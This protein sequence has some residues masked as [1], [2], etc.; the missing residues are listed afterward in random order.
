MNYPQQAAGYQKNAMRIIAKA[1]PPMFLS[2]VQFQTGL[3]SRLMHAGMTV[4][5]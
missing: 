5:G 2:V 3:D 4:F 1:S